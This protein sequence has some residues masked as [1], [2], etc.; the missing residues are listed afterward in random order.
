[1]AD[2][3]LTWSPLTEDRW[4][5]AFHAGDRAAVGQCYRDHFRTVASAVGRVLPAADSE[6][7]THEVFY[8][9]LSDATLRENFQGGN[10]AGWIARVATH[11]AID[12]L[13][14]SRREQSVFGVSEVD[15]LGTAQR[16]DDE[17]DA[18]VLVDRFR[19][20]CL[21]PEWDGVF[22]ARFLRQASQR[23]A[24]RELGIHRTTLAYR[25]LR[26]R[27]LLTRFLLWAEHP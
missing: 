6:T 25:E 1:V 13:R 24:A 7:V 16:V 12:Y 14:R 18:K 5:A 22:E 4:L 19:R 10:F 8:R 11:G 3:Q 9:L 27:R 26:I 15:T 23:E 20:E 17:L 21:P 2:A